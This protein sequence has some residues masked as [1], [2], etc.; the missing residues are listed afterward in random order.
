MIYWF[1]VKTNSEKNI[2]NIFAALKELIFIQESN[3]I[4]IGL[5]IRV[6]IEKIQLL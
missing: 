2:L 4:F 1:Q 3:N 5:Y 6:E